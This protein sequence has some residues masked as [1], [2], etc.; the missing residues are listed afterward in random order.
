[1][2]FSESLGDCGTAN[3]FI[4][5]PKSGRTWVR[6]VLSLAEVRVKFSHGGHGTANLKEVVGKV[7]AMTGLSF[8]ALSK[9]SG[10]KVIRQ[11]EN[12]ASNVVR[13]YELE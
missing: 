11:I 8:V 7:V 6:Y 10:W 9:R 12:G 5:Y 4:S 1:M 3:A 2:L 13:F